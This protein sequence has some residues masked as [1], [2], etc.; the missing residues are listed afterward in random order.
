MLQTKDAEY[1]GDILVLLM[2]FPHPY[3]SVNNTEPI[4][5]EEF[6]LGYINPKLCSQYSPFL[7]Y[8]FSFGEKGEK[9]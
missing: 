8:V 5:L 2:A 6:E 4:T 3:S 1:Q 9:C 7:L